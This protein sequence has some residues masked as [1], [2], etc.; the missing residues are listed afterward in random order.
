MHEPTF[1][2]K[3]KALNELLSPK[4]VIND[5][6]GDCIPSLILANLS[7]AISGKRMRT[8]KTNLMKHVAINYALFVYFITVGKDFL[9]LSKKLK[10]E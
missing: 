1:L 10:I 5:F 9:T 8:R 2:F 3:D 7:H 6:L 4:N